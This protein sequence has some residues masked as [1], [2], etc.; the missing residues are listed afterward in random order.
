[1]NDLISKMLSCSNVTQIRKIYK[2][3]KATHIILKTSQ[4]PVASLRIVLTVIL[5]YN[6]S[7]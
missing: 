4:L 7:F 3:T 2:A 5:C 1:M 6:D